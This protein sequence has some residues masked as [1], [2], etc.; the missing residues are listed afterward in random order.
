MVETY[1]VQ[2]FFATFYTL[3][4]PAERTVRE[5]KSPWSKSELLIRPP[6]FDVCCAMRARL[7]RFTAVSE[8]TWVFEM[9]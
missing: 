2:E 4:S 1:F 7:I 3:T 6:T 9:G 8:W 5:N